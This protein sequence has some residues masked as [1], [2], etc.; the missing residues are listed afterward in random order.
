MTSMKKI[1]NRLKVKKWIYFFVIILLL[2]AKGNYRAGWLSSYVVS[3]PDTIPFQIWGLIGIFVGL[4]LDEWD[5]KKKRKDKT[6]QKD[7]K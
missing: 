1:N 3:K 2:Y 7:K 6:E 5:K 4:L